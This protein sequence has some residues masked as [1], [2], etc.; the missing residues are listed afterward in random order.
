MKNPKQNESIIKLYCMKKIF[1]SAIPVA[2]FL[3]P[4]FS[5]NI[6]AKD[7]G[8]YAGKT[9]TVCDKIYGGKFLNSSG[10]KPTFLNVGA[11]Y[12]NAPFTVVIWEADRKK[13]KFKPEEF[14][15]GKKVCIT[16]EIKMYKG[17][18]EVEVSDPKQIVVT[19]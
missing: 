4:A 5:Q 13:F 11:D 17:K 2:F 3:F 12:P 14:F 10:N 16:G 7:A 1:L 15:K 6:S 8:K 9:V 18:P 19:E